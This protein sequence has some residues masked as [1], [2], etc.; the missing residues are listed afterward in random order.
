MKRGEYSTAPLEAR[1][2]A[3]VVRRGP[4]ECWLWTGAGNRY[5]TIKR[6]YKSLLAHRVS[7]AMHKGPIPEGMCVCHSCDNPKCVNPAHL[8]LGT[9]AE[10][11]A[12]KVAK[13]RQ[14]RAAGEAHHSSKL[15]AADVA[16]I[17]ASTE[18]GV[19][20]AARYGVTPPTISVIRNGKSWRAA[21]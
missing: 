13:G 19:I 17:R 5:G 1:F 12:D 4:K 11:T 18:K 3:Q 9:N 21:A 2:W 10:N 8:W 20:L 7:Y 14:Y 15:S 16:A 6:F